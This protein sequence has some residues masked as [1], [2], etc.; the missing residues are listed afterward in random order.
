M[1]K[2]ATGANL[3]ENA[4][5]PIMWQVEGHGFGQ[6]IRFAMRSLANGGFLNRAGDGSL[7]LSPQPA[8]IW[9]MS[10]TVNPPQVQLFAPPAAPPAALPAPSPFVRLRNTSSKAVVNIETGSAQL[11]PADDGWWSADWEMLEGTTPSGLPA[12]AFKNRWK[13]TYLS[14]TDAGLVS[15]APTERG[16]HFWRRMLDTD[17]HNGEVRLQNAATGRYLALVNNQLITSNLVGYPNSFAWFID[18]H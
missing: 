12:V 15:D 3:P 2:E 14:D 5:Y 18:P 13:G 1:L 9:K 10:D 6:E 4:N 16:N 8:Y 11:S 17:S 7:I